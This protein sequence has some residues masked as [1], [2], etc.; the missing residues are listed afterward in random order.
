LGRPWNYYCSTVSTSIEYYC[1]IAGLKAKQVRASFEDSFLLA[2]KSG[3]IE[4]ND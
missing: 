1:P 2:S 4:T 3:A